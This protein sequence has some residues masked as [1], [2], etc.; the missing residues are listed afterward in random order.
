MLIDYASQ[1]HMFYFW[2]FTLQ[3]NTIVINNCRWI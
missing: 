2:S 1:L 3:W